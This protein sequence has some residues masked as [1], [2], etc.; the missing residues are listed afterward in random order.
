MLKKHKTNKKDLKGLREGIR[1]C[2]KNIEQTIKDLNGLREGI[3]CSKTQN[4]QQ[5]N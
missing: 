4:K 3:K 5:R 2:S 1:W